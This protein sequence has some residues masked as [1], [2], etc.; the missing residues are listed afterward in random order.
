MYS[1]DTGRGNSREGG[2]TA[3]P[4][5]RAGSAMPGA[6]PASPAAGAAGRA[7]CARTQRWAQKDHTV[8]DLI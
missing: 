8:F 7:H 5:S 4:A 6:S 3:P 1:R 2:G